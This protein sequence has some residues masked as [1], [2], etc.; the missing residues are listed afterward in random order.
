M[1]S[2]LTR[3]V[4][5]WSIRAG[6]AFRPRTAQLAI[7]LLAALGLAGCVSSI[8]NQTTLQFSDETELDTLREL[9]AI[10]MEQ[11]ERQQDY[12]DVEPF[13][14]IFPLDD[15]ALSWT[16]MFSMMD[17]EGVLIFDANGDGLPDVYISSD[18]QN[19]TRP[20]DKNGVLVDKPRIQANMLYLNQGNDAAGNP[21]YRSM[22]KLVESGNGQLEAEELVIEGYLFPRTSANDPTEDRLGRA[23]TLAVSADFNADGLPDLLVANKPSG[24]V[25]SSEETREFQ[26]QFIDPIGRS[27]KD[28]AQ[29]LTPL[30]EY[31]VQHKAAYSLYDKR[32]SSRPDG[33]EFEGA[34]TLY[35]NL[36][37]QDGDGIPEWKDVSR[38]AGIEG[39][40]P[41]T[42]LCVADFDLDGDLDVFEGNRMDEDYWTGKSSKIA[43]GRNCLFVNQLAETGALRFNETG[44][45]SNVD[46][47][48]DDDNPMPAYHRIKRIPFLP[49]WVSL[50]FLIDDPYQP[51]FLTLNGQQC[52]PGTMTWASVVQDVN[53][54]GLPDI[55]VGNDMGWL[56]LY[57]NKG[58]MQFEKSEHAR[59]VIG[60]NWMG[61]APADFNN[62][63]VEDLW[64]GNS[65]GGLLNAAASSFPLRVLFDPPIMV[66]VAM[67]QFMVG[68]H[69]GSHALIDGA[70]WLRELTNY[71][72][73]SRVLP[74]DVTIPS[75]IEHRSQQML[76][77]KGMFD[78]NSMD[79]YEFAWGSAVL[80]VQNDGLLDLYWVGGLA[81]RGGSLR[82]IGINPGRLLV[83]KPTLGD[84]EVRFADETAEH[85]V[86]NIELMEY[87]RLKSDGYLY[88]R[89]PSQNWK[90][91]DMVYSYD[92]SVWSAQGPVIS[93][94]VVNQDLLRC[95]E[96]GRGA[97]AADLNG[98]G[99]Q[100]L[101]VRNKGGYDSMA[102][103]AQ[104]LK[105]NIDGK[106]RVIPSHHYSFPPL[107]NYE[108]GSTRVWMNRYSGKRWLK[109][110]LV[111][112]GSLNRDA[113]GAQVIVNDKWLRVKRAGEGSFVSNLLIPLHFGMADESA[114]SIEVRWPDKERSVTRYTIPPSANKT[115]RISKTGGVL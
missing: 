65:G 109:V 1:K 112:E 15:D 19:W 82:S 32:A 25:W 6:G 77:E 12:T 114:T 104:N 2:T 24:M 69:D 13:E 33:E 60:G 28:S 35:L 96:N 92:R 72:E 50:L 41:T 18:G 38:E 100:D 98:D 107:T 86:F 63:L 11:A 16:N 44:A 88:R 74:P 17:G 75:N 27:I 66:S 7:V 3:R 80:D 48:Y 26:A 39:Q 111:D 94:R 93:E 95:A 58:G 59:S 68:A 4:A 22:K 10:A 55:W 9:N 36:G 57:M 87:D 70:N 21:I 5:L 30:G 51:E 52:E 101:I 84:E 49:D 89:A 54:D 43:G 53:H 99:Y 73:H 29:P 79:A 110:D 113:I 40:R 76:V 56:N 90:K 91:R 106:A 31:L 85:N 8:M 14:E 45:E 61:F 23:A 42:V 103:D 102:P 34:N 46:D 20:T 37:D 62:D 71:V 115:L 81:T 83:N 108:A 64:G 97:I 105:A 67:A 78:P 47:Q